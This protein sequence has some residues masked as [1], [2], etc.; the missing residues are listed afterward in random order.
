LARRFRETGEI[1][2]VDYTPREQRVW[3]YVAE[4]LAEMHEKHAS[5]FYLKAK[6]DLGITT[7]RIPQL[8][9]NEPAAERVDRLSPCTDRRTGR[10][11]SFSKLAVLLA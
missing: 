1:T 8:T 3:R 11:A 7:E 9:E 6:R 2:D 5:P 4:E 10:N